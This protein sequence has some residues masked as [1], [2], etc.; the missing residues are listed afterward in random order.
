MG[1]TSGDPQK[2]KGYWE[3]RYKK[4]HNEAMQRHHEQEMQ[5]INQQRNVRN[6]GSG[7]SSCFVAT[8]AF[9]T[10]EGEELDFLR[11]YRDDKLIPHPIG[12]LFVKWYYKNGPAIASWVKPYP[13]A[14]SLTRTILK[15]LIKQL[16]RLEEK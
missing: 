15:K 12:K 8:V 11:K 2:E 13:Y 5:R 16:K 1:V 7:S 9:E 4:E 14:R 6:N 3:D 10:S